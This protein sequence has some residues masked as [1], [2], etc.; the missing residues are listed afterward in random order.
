MNR[1]YLLTALAGFGLAVAPSAA[2]A[3]EGD[4][5]AL[6]VEGVI[7]ISDCHAEDGQANCTALSVLGS[8]V[9]GSNQEGE[10]ETGNT[11]IGGE[12]PSGSGGGHV[13]LFGSK[14][15]VDGGGNSQ[16]ESA[17]VDVNVGGVVHVQVLRAQAN[18]NGEAESDGVYLN[19]GGE[20]I[21]ILHAH[22]DGEKGSAAAAILAG[23]EILGSGEDGGV[24]CPL[25]AGPV[26]EADV[27]CAA[28]KRAG[29]VDDASV[30]DGTVTGEV[31]TANSRNAEDDT[32]TPSPEPEPEPAP[33]PGD[34][35]P[36]DPLTRTGGD[37]LELLMLGGLALVT[38][39]ALRRRADNGLGVTFA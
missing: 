15:S 21:H 8:E 33:G 2:F 32:L 27:I 36:E 34:E 17:A 5:T 18:S 25:P 38:G 30:V 28:G 16:S 12:D 11:G 10:G 13:F 29:V 35:G 24:M 14:S 9:A 1:K 31:I 23:N 37:L 19:I 39:E 3:G 4:A 26:A 7:T 20:E 6:H 22:S